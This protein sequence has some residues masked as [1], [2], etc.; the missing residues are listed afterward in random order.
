MPKLLYTELCPEC[1][2]RLRRSRSRGLLEKL[3]SR[4]LAV[5]CFR[6]DRCSVRFKQSPGIIARARSVQESKKSKHRSLAADDLLIETTRTVPKTAVA[7]QTRSPEAS[8]DIAAVEAWTPDAAASNRAPVRWTESTTM[9]VRD[10]DQ[11]S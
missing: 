3:L 8:H 1:G 11:H 2:G 7:S 10:K 9:F 4:L 6:C 5:H